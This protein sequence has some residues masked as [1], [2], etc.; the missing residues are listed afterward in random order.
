MQQTS[1]RICA[2]KK[3]SLAVAVLGLS[4][5]VA[6]P[7]QQYPTKPIRFVAPSSTGG[8]IDALARTIANSPHGL[9][10]PIIVENRGGANGII[11]TDIVAKSAPDGYTILLGFLGA[12]AVNPSL[13]A[14]LPYDPVKDFAP[15]TQVTAAPPLIVAHPTVPARTLKELVKLDKSRPNQLTYGT[16]GIGT[17]GHL[18]MELFN[19]TAGTKL[20]HV[21]YKGVGPALSDVIAGQI[22]LMV[23]SPISS[24]PHVQSGR[25]RGLAVAGRSRAAVMPDVPTVIESGWPDFESTSWFGVLAPAGTPPAIVARLHKE[26]TG[27]LRRPEVREQITRTGADVVGNSPEEFGAYIKTEIVKWA[28][29]VKAA[30][31]KVN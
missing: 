5:P 17:G 31:I 6:A 13:Y 11:G 10:Q 1:F 2:I 23:S 9:G 18:T 20:L 22:T 27:Q 28:K 29:V 16:G 30:N 14:K 4:L 21:P 7:A 15:I 26:I 24:A 3:F 12:L 8:G 25:L 19:L